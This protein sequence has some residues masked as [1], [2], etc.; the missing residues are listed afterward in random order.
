MFNI[1]N[2]SRVNYMMKI[3]DLN[4]NYSHIKLKTNMKSKKNKREYNNLK[5]KLTHYK[6]NCR[7]KKMM[8][9]KSYLFTYLFIY[10]N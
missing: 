9:I 6:V 4:N 2:N 10:S 1:T 5:M 3:I 7:N 8:V